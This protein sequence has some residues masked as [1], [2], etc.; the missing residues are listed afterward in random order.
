M[1]A[2]SDKL[3]AAGVDTA[4]AK[5]Y[6]TAVDLLRKQT[7][8]QAAPAFWQRLIADRYLRDALLRDYLHRVATDMAAGKK[9]AGEGQTR[10]E[11]QG[12]GAPP[13]AGSVS[14]K[15]YK[16]P[17]Y[18]RRTQEEKE[19]A[20]DA[21]MK[22]LDAIYERK[23]GRM[24]LGDIAWE[25]LQSLAREAADSAA[26]RLMFGLADTEDAILLIKAAEHAHVDDGRTPVR[27]VIPATTLAKYAE[28]ARAEAPRIIE[29]GMRE[30]A[31]RIAKGGGA[32]EH[33][34]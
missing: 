30:Q 19:A 24:V 18:R 28:E 17:P 1:T 9:A 32:I 16:V 3:K 26:R 4:A 21:K 23:I 25:S 14:V 29:I 31:A 22:T 15:G 8:E 6:T 27:A 12:S 11:I 10:H 2:M 7:P 20:M 34:P 5:L 33:A 13:A